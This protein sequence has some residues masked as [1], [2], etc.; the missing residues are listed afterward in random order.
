MKKSLAI[1]AFLSLSML[2]CGGSESPN[3]NSANVANT[4][5]T[6]NIANTNIINAVNNAVTNTP[7]ADVP[8]IT[9]PENP[10]TNKDSNSR[11]KPSVSNTIKETN[12]NTGSNRPI[13]SNKKVDEIINNQNGTVKKEA[14][15]LQKNVEKLIK[16]LP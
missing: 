3:T 6:A 9:E 2:A 14:Q 10:V 7:V 1:T 13:Q 8:K 15:K 5:N 11:T 16:D 4:A 12:S